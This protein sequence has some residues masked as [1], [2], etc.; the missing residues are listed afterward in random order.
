MTIT[1]EG[2]TAKEKK[3]ITP[4]I[5]SLTRI[6]PWW[7]NEL[8]VLKVDSL[9]DEAEMECYPQKDARR[10]TIKVPNQTLLFE[11]KAL[12]HTFVHE[13]AHCYNEPLTSLIE[14][15]EDYITDESHVKVMNKS[16][17]RLIEEQTEDLAIMFGDIIE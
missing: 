5:K 2:F 3:R 4:F 9:E 15:L 16:V 1:I 7:L 14:V 11:D 6:A 10:M 8:H 12:K 13:M 17:T